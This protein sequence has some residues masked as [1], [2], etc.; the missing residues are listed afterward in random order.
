MMCVCVCQS[1]KQLLLLLHRESV[2]NTAK[3]KVCERKCLYCH[4]K[5]RER[6]RACVRLF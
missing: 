6:V 5:I 3:Q 4:F 2:I 1:N